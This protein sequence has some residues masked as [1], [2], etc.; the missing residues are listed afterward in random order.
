MLHPRSVA[1]S[2]SLICRRLSNR[3]GFPP[4]V[5]PR[6]P[7]VFS[8]VFDIY[9]VLCQRLPRRAGAAGAGAHHHFLLH[10]QLRVLRRCRVAFCN[11]AYPGQSQEGEES[12]GNS[13]PGAPG[14]VFVPGF[15][16]GPG[17]PSTEEAAACRRAS[18]G[19]LPRRTRPRYPVAAQ[20]HSPGLSLWSSCPLGRGG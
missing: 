9:Q 11:V 3:P 4:L 20:R 8:V 10:H 15:N 18:R 6:S 5:G 19:C 16:W 17:T 12:T 13:V 1:S 14:G 7:V 2:Y